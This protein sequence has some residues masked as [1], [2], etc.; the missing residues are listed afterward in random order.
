MP[1]AMTLDDF[2]RRILDA[3]RMDARLSN[4]DLAARVGL[5]HSAISRRVRRMEEQGV[6]RGYHA[7]VDPVAAGQGAGLRQRPTRAGNAGR[8]P[9]R[10]LAAIAEVTGVWILSGDFDLMIEIVAVDMAAY[11]RIMLERVQTTA[12]VASTHS[13]FVLATVRE[14]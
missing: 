6:I 11:A 8:R 7:A 1:C 10:K 4:V 9:C 13:M 2:D 12:G 5:S 3:L 14:P